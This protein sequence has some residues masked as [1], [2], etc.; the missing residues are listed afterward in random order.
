MLVPQLPLLLTC[1]KEGELKLGQEIHRYCL[2]HAMFDTNPQLETTMIG[3]YMK[4]DR[5]ASCSVLDMMVKKNVVC[6]REMI[7]GY[8]EVGD[9]ERTLEVFVQLHQEGFEFDSIKILVVFQACAEYGSL[10]VT[11]QI[12]QAALNFGF[13]ND[14]CVVIALLNMYKELG[15]LDLTCFLFEGNP[16]SD[17]ALWNSMMSTYIEFRK[18]EETLNVL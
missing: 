9:Y 15:R 1:K 2:R 12:H 3:F 10:K 18:P 16:S 4:F 13:F 8:F 14:L 7:T 11:T 5:R 6:W 17:V